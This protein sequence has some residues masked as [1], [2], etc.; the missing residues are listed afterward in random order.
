MSPI[1]A[2]ACGDPDAG[3]APVAP[4][5]FTGIAWSE[6]TWALWGGCEPESAGCLNCYAMNDAW[7]LGR[8]PKVPAYAGLVTRDEHSGR[9][10]WTG[11]TRYLAS[12]SRAP[13]HWRRPLYVFTSSMT[14]AHL[15]G[16]PVEWRVE[17]YATMVVAHWH[18]FQVLTKHSRE[19]REWFRSPPLDSIAAAAS[20]MASR[21]GQPVLYDP[22]ASGAHTRLGVE[23]RPLLWPPPNVWAGVSTESQRLLER[24]AEDLVLT[25][26]ART[27]LSAEPCIER[28]DGRGIFG[29]VS[30]VL[31]GGESALKREVARPFKP[32]W[33]AAAIE[34]SRA[35]GSAPFFKQFGSIW[36][37]EHGLPGKGDDPSRWPEEFRVQE[38]PRGAR[39]PAPKRKHLPVLEAAA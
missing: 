4:R 6:K 25:G 27:F 12:A 20:A 14:D 22:A 32:E 11:E 9:L 17:L 33:G 30:Q 35:E 13:L 29:R 1:E 10:K 21:P 38:M 26:A 18:T 39:P 31:I 28:L 36:A 3:R 16:V 5:R 23:V 37:M 2:V 34:V 24:R 19:M 7:R 8:N 15:P